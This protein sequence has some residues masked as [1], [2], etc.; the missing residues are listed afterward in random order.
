MVRRLYSRFKKKLLSFCLKYDDIYICC[1]AI[2][3][4]FFSFLSL[5]KYVYMEYIG[6]LI[7]ASISIY[8]DEKIDKYVDR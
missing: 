6:R 3:A 5:D 4:R 7:N 8:I 2:R 1:Q